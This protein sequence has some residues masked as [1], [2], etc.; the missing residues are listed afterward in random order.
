MPNKK[1]KNTTTNDKQRKNT[2]KNPVTLDGDKDM[3]KPVKGLK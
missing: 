3:T 2:G 1:D